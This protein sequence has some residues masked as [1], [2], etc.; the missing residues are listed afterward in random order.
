MAL[1]HPSAAASRPI[2]RLV[3]G[4]WLGA[5]AFWLAIAAA[6]G[7][8]VQQAHD[9]ALAT[10]RARA[11][12]LADS[13]AAHTNRTLL[14]A[15]MALAGLAE[16]LRPTLD[17]RVPHGLDAQAAHRLLVALADRHLQITNVALLDM[18]GRQLA[19]GLAAT[20]AGGM[21][22]PEGFARQVLAAHPGQLMISP[23]VP[24]GAN[25]EPAVYAAR[26]LPPLPGGL[27][28]LAVAEVPVSVLSVIAEYTQ[29]EPGLAFSL[30]RRD[31]LLV[32]SM[33]RHDRLDGHRL[34]SALPADQ[35][36]GLAR[37]LPGRLS[38]RPALVAARP[39]LH[40]DLLS[41]ASL[42]LGDGL[43]AWRTGRRNAWTV[44]G[45]F[46]LLIILAAAA[47]QWQLVQL[48]QARRDLSR[49]AATLDQALASMDEGFL[50]TDADDR[51]L[52]WNDRYVELFPWLSGVIAPGLPFRRLAEAAAAHA[53]D[54]SSATARQRWIEE[55]I[56][57][58]RAGDR[59]WEQK[60][61][62]GRFVSALER[63]TPEGGVVSVYR[64]VTATE[65]R[66]AHARDA[67][68]EASRAK[69][70]FLANM[71]HE[72]RT[73][74]NALMGINE[75]LLRSPLA[76]EQRHHLEL[77][78]GSGRL[79]LAL[80]N[81]LL[82]LSRIEEGQ[83]ALERLPYDPARVCDEVVQLMRER[84]A[85]QGLALSFEAEAG[86]PPTLWGD[87]VRLRQVLFN[88]VGNAL[89]FTE[90]GSVHVTL[91][92]E[93]PADTAAAVTMRLAVRDTGIG[94]T[95]EQL[96]MLFERFTQGDTS[97]AR[98][99]GG[100]G[101]GL[102]ISRRIVDLMGGTIGVQSTPSTGSCFEV[103]WPG[104]PA[105]PATTGHG[106]AGT[107]LPAQAQVQA[108]VPAQ[109]PVQASA[110]S[111]LPAAASAAPLFILVA[112]DH[113]VNQVLIE[114]MLARLGHRCEIVGDGRAA[115]RR[116]G[117]GGFDLVLMDM[118][119]PELDGL[120]AT[121][122]I[123]ALPGNAAALPIVAM[124]ANARSEDRAAC[125]E[126]GMDDYVSKPIDLDALQGAMA[127]AR[128]C[129][130]AR[131]RRAAPHPAA[132]GREAQA[133]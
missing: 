98:R 34:A 114:A 130:Q 124:T 72:I 65:R 131:Q 55:R 129:A 35:T 112:E 11:V 22:M 110:P 28:L 85:A 58:H 108:Q 115:V 57:L 95:A 40:G 113:A 32:A 81:D 86:V 76:P 102:A 123:R 109:A 25:G 36:D 84:A 53:A 7:H 52:R 41:V 127:R 60:L 88:L 125:L 91:R 93:R 12:V 14:G 13:S 21:V 94:I 103:Q 31:G 119:M 20:Q 97:I 107:A 43:A 132:P 77:A 128:D 118:Q 51:V 10:L 49:S 68:E 111:P 66:L 64:D 79:L 42:D 3:T 38:G 33:P 9:S 82:D 116:A 96:P 8:W 46:L 106:A 16:L 71:S 18:R 6:T 61:A 39:M 80:I 69:S 1:P 17:P 83:L 126:A 70:E 73:P 74:L 47:A 122:G 99:Y 48:T 89:K 4:L 23:P 50:L 15:D 19:T 120:A 62:N 104:E 121:R 27:D 44:A 133:A 92:A 78:R 37:A 87:P 63:R 29:H 67:A 100:S 24:A 30:E 105:G 45:G 90:R 75:L 2:K 26:R 5:L 117:D 56:A 54:D 59:Q 101:L